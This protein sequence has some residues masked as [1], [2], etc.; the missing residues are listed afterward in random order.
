VLSKRGHHCIVFT[1]KPEVN[2]Y[3]LET[4]ARTQISIP[5]KFGQCTKIHVERTES[6]LI[7]QFYDKSFGVFNLV[8]KQFVKRIHDVNFSKCFIDANCTYLAGPD[9]RGRGIDFYWF[10]WE[11]E[12]S[13]FEKPKEQKE[14]KLNLKVPMPTKK[15]EQKKSS[16]C[17][18][19]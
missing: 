3:D 2:M 15:E 19:F 9:V 8:E 5:P 6:V 14:A 10:K 1:S 16:F 13:K 11:N 7:S 4:T 12:I 17:L 18:L